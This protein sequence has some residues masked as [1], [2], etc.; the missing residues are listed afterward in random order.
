MGE[1]ILSFRRSQMNLDSLAV[2]GHRRKILAV[3]VV[4]MVL[5]GLTPATNL[6][7]SP[8]PDDWD[9]VFDTARAVLAE[10]PDVAR[11]EATITEPALRESV[12]RAYRALKACAKVN[13]DQSN[14]QKRAF[15][16]EFETAYRS[17]Q[18]EVERGDHRD[19]AAA[20]TAESSKC[21]K[22]CQSAKKKVC[23]CKMSEFGCVMKCLFG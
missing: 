10:L 16:A 2:T 21:Q 6:R 4:G 3:F 13:R 19:C 7:A 11:I 17:V 9:E 15:V 5:C 12:L 1:D 20:C 8:V 18:T 22:G 14:S 23:P